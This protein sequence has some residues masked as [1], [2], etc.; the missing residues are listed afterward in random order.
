MCLHR[1]I[2]AGCKDYYGK[3]TRVEVVGN[4]VKH[5]GVHVCMYGPVEISVITCS[6]ENG[7]ALGDTETN[8]IYGGFLYID[9]VYFYL[10]GH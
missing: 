8:E 5:T 2:R 10:P 3:L 9:S 1:T 4:L 7:V 6:D